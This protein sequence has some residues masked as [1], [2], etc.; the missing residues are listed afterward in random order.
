[1]CGYGYVHVHDEQGS[2]IEFNQLFHDRHKMV[3]AQP[4]VIARTPASRPDTRSNVG[5]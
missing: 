3:S 4:L 2:T 5:G 1:M